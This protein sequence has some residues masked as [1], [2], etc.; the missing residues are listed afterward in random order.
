MIHFCS[1]TPTNILRYIPVALHAVWR[2]E[3]EL[4]QPLFYVIW[5]SA[6]KRTVIT[7]ANLRVTFRIRR[8]VKGVLLD[9][10]FCTLFVCAPPLDTPIWMEPWC[11]LS[12][13][14]VHNVKRIGNRASSMK[15]AYLL[16]KAVDPPKSLWDGAFKG[17][18]YDHQDSAFSMLISAC[19]T[20]C[21]AKLSLRI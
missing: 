21:C 18:E 9:L 4:A 16:R 12:T 3:H 1:G 15:V 20:S 2:K 7:I 13:F 6:N 8:C 10:E 5:R 14:S 17:V 19:Y 11:F